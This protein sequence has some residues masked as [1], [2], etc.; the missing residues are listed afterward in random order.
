MGGPRHVLAFAVVGAL[1]LAGCTPAPA[2]PSA[3][4]T[5]EG[6][7]DPVLDEG[8]ISAALDGI[9]SAPGKDLDAARLASGLVPPTNRWFSGLVFGATAQ[10]VF[11]L[12]LSFGLT[13]NGFA[14]GV[15][16][17]VTSEKTIM[18][19]YRPSVQ[20]TVPGLA[21]WQ[22]TAYDELSVTL[23]AR[24]DTGVLGTLVI[25]EGSPLVTYTAAAGQTLGV[26]PAF[27]QSGGVW[28]AE[29][30]GRAYAAVARNGS[31]ASGSVALQ[32]GGRVTWIAVP[33]GADAADV[34]ASAAAITGTSVAYAVSDRA[35]TTLRYGTD[36]DAPTLVAALP[37]QAANLVGSACDLGTY[38]S[39]LGTM[40]LCAGT[41]LAWTSPAWP[42][43]TSLDLGDLTADETAELERALAD[44]L[45]GAAAY[46]AD[47]YFG[48]K[49][50]Y[51]DAQSYTIARQIGADD[52][53]ADLRQKVTAELETWTNPAGCRAASEKCFF[54]DSTTSGIV[55]RTASFGSDE[56]NDHHFHYGYFLYAAGVMA[57][58]DPALAERI[59]PVMNLLAADIAASPASERFPQRRVFDVYASHSWASGTAPFAD[60]NNQESASEAVTAWS[61][62]TL[63]ARASGNTALETEAIWMH[64]LEAQAANAYWTDFDTADP[65]Y[66]GF[67]HTVT[68]LVFGGKRD[69]AT[70]FSAEPAA[71]LAILVLPMSPSSDHLAVDPGR[72]AANVAEAVGEKGFRQPYGDYLLMYSALQGEQ[73][74]VAALAAARELPADLIDDGVSRTYLLAW[75]FGLRQR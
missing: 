53:A 52:I 9:G 45:A 41:E 59:A 1:L 23:T 68:P 20:V 5:R 36:G 74:R 69:Y 27:A 70:W 37:H 39:I 49:A 8:E 65:V 30:E 73:Q 4:T 55:G 64:A 13:P 62:L 25:A 46:P 15:P 48:G 7:T 56:F 34:V 17:V 72:I 32:P 22:V 67:G 24:S 10:P 75:L 57:A 38:P 12:P 51:R 54:Y 43:R 60:G 26:A 14:F 19:G 2:A 50:L 33:D 16:D 28:R 31:V 61:G 63:W 11:P 66:D 44:D 3:P 35:T 58:D 42:A 29:A 18:G 40:R 21:T 47:T 6:G 71:A